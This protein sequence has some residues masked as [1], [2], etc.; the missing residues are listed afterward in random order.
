MVG[1]CVRGF[2]SA[3]HSQ[4]M[5]LNRK[6]NSEVGPGFKHLPGKAMSVEG[7]GSCRRASQVRGGH[8]V[9]SIAAAQQNRQRA[10]VSGPP[11]VASWSRL[12]HTHHSTTAGFRAQNSEKRAETLVPGF[13]AFGLGML[14]DRVADKVADSLC[15]SVLPENAWER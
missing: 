13:I 12:Q 8:G 6:M 4:T 15:L 11:H 9:E 10:H 7:V 2:K 3:R 1:A 5:S 14:A